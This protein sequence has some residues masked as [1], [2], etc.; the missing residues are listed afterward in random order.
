MKSTWIAIATLAA[1]ALP[2]G[3][4]AQG[5]TP[6]QVQLTTG[7]STRTNQRGD[8]L[9]A[10]VISPP[11]YRG[12][13]MEGSIKECSGSG[14]A[15]KRSTLSF[16][17]AYL[18]HQ[19]QRI[20]VHSEITGFTNSKGRQNVD[21]EG[22]IVEK[23]NDIGK[24]LLLTGIGTGIG[25]AAGGA[26]GAAIGAGAGAAVGLLFIRFGSKAPN[27]SFDSGSQFDLMVSRRKE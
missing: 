19:N 9:T 8:K 23:K 22:Q 26:K 15:N 10:M 7:I 21:E 25:A 24:A 18:F 14:V 12:D 6:F 16:G 11:Q 3:S 2:A 13:V 5:Q 4:W 1:L 27:L 17:F 20:P